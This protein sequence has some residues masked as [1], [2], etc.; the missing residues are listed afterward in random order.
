[1]SEDNKKNARRKS[2]VIAVEILFMYYSR[3]KKISIEDCSDFVLKEIQE[4]TEED[5]FSR[6]II[7]LVIDNYSKI[8]LIIKTITTNLP[9]EKIVLINKLILM[10]GIVE[11]KYIGTPPIV[12]INEYVEIAKS[13]GENKSGSFI[14]GVLD[15]FRQNLSQ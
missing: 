4:N 5:K 2:R 11:I 14:N 6:K 7:D 12:V 9:S 1:M 8:S 13:F 10:L 15:S 3:D